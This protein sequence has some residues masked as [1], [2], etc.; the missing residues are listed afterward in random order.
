MTRKAPRSVPGSPEPTRSR[1]CA[2][3]SM[4]ICGS[5]R[6]AVC[7]RS[8]SAA[9]RAASALRTAGKSRTRSSLPAAT[10]CTFSATD[11][12]MSM[13]PESSRNSS[14]K[15]A[16]ATCS[17]ACDAV[18]AA[19]AAVTR[20][21]ARSTSLTGPPPS[22]VR[23]SRKASRER[24]AS[25]LSRASS[26]C[27]RARTRSY[28]AST[29]RSARSP[30]RFCTRAAVASS[31]PRAAPTPAWVAPKSKISWRNDTPK[32]PVS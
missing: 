17:R 23:C 30:S 7:S 20:V 19:K 14:R 26:L 6:A 29:E 15:A 27:D 9:R 31:R 24:T 18:Q 25:R 22:C 10:I 21:C 16:A 3:S 12:G 11:T 5:A 2:D 1:R 32:P 28:Q 4:L 13:S 8:C